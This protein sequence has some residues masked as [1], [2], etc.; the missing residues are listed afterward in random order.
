LLS[1]NILDTPHA[2]TKKKSEKKP[3]AG[4]KQFPRPTQLKSKEFRTAAGG[5]FFCTTS[6]PLP[7]LDL[8]ESFV[9]P[10]TRLNCRVTIEVEQKLATV[11]HL[12][13]QL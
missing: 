9:V 7:L 4:C 3:L 6:L 1:V 8:Q 13:R 5:N 10:S 2:K 11:V 12:Q